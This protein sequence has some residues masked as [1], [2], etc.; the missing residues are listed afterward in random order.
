MALRPSPVPWAAGSIRDVLWMSAACSTAAA[1]GAF[2]FVPET[3]WCT[4]RRMDWPGAVSLSAGL[5]VLLL[6]LAKRL[7][8]WALTLA[9]GLAL[10]SVTPLNHCPTA[11]SSRRSRRPG[12]RVS[13]CRRAARQW[14]GPSRVSNSPELGSLLLQVLHA[15][16]DVGTARR[17]RSQT[18]SA[19]IARPVASRS[20][21]PAATGRSRP[22]G[23]LVIV[24]VVAG[25]IAWAGRLAVAGLRGNGAGRRGSR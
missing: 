7:R 21:K 15:R 25:A 5:A 1:A 10:G 24:G 23:G 19:A 11:R 8:S 12:R 6:A 2:A 20:R 18:Q 22:A 16:T 9:L 17:R 13:R 14:S 3:Q 4:P